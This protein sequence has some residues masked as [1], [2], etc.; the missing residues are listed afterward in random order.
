[1]AEHCVLTIGNFDG[2]HRG[3]QAILA[4][5]KALAEGHRA[6]VRAITFDPHPASILR[7][8]QTPPRLTD[9]PRR[10]D[11]LRAAGA[12]EVVILPPTPE[13]LS[14]TPERFIQTLVRAQNP[15][16][17][18]EGGDF[19]FGKGRAGDVNTLRELGARY[20]FEVE[21][22]APVEV[23]LCDQLLAPVSSSLIRWL[24]RRGRVADAAR[25][26][27]RAYELS[28][29]VVEGERR[30]R[31]IGVPTANLDPSIAVGRAIPGAGV[32]AGYALT[33]EQTHPAAIS[34][35]QKP[36]FQGRSLAIEAHLLDFSGELYGR[37]LTLRFTRW[38]RDQQAFPGVDA[39]KAQL[40]RDIAQARAWHGLGVLD[41]TTCGSLTS[42][43][44]R[45]ASES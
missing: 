30:G 14:Q 39:L 34:V 8:D 11:L 36:T 20:G 37:P 4:R 24:L 28:G 45:I 33:G 15:A 29:K 1:M 31:T 41:D 18:V 2:V 43:A 26:L 21:V 13:L 40:H 23:A 6:S 17:M 32:Y 35:G 12:D 5:A 10:A 3:H 27:G 42:T 16:A 22:V 19:R 44:H 7:P 25:A 9:A 38:L